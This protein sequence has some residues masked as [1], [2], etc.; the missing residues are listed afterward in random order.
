MYIRSLEE[1]FLNWPQDLTWK[2]LTGLFI[3]QLNDSGKLLLEEID[4]VA[5]TAGPGL[6]VC[7][8]VGLSFGKAFA[9]AFRKTIYCC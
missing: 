4:A 3:K 6:I 9:S 5:A 8:S 1:L 7:L 2:K